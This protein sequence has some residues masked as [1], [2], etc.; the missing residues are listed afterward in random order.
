[1]EEVAEAVETA[2]LGKTVSSVL[3]GQRS[4]DLVVRAEDANRQSL[5]AIRA[6]LIDT[7]LGGKVPLGF[8]GRGKEGF[9]AKYDKPRRTC[10]ERSSSAPTSPGEICKESCATSRTT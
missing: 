2:F 3:E 6:T 10:K 7:P 9:G 8:A 4:F 5:E 1:M